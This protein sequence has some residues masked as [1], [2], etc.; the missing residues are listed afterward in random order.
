MSQ[1]IAEGTPEM[2]ALEIEFEDR[3]DMFGKEVEAANQFYYS[4]MAIHHTYSV[5]QSVKKALDGHGLVTMT[6]LAGLQT[7][8]IVTLGRIFDNE[9]NYTIHKLLTF[10]REHPELFTTEALRARKVRANYPK[11]VDS[12]IDRHFSHVP[13][14]EDFNELGRLLR[15]HRRMYND[16]LDDIRDK[17]FAHREVDSLK[18]NELFAKTDLGEVEDT[19]GFLLGFGSA[20]WQWYYNGTKPV[21]SRD[22]DAT[23]RDHPLS[24][25]FSMRH[26]QRTAV[27]MEMFL[28]LLSPNTSHQ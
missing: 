5:D 19:L 4:S 18:A 22:F 2:R 6:V 17:W 16:K 27:E 21:V 15:P 13:T 8:M 3:L 9:S 12:W 26:Q 10:M 28:K 14:L 20:I 24:A 1:P 25:R 23:E 7:S 11:P